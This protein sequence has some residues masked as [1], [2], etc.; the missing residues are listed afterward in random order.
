MEEGWTHHI[1]RL[2]VLSNI[3][4][5]LD[6]NPR[7]LTDWFHVAFI[8]AYDWVVEPNVL[9]M[10]TFATGS[11][12]MTKPYVAGS[13]YINRMSDHCS[14]CDFHPKKTCPISRMYWAYLARHAPAFSGNHRLSMAMRNVEKRSEE[15][16]QL[17]HATFLHVQQTLAK[18]GKLTPEN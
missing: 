9:G 12:M 4:H 11:A 16:R 6:V 17:D 2:M 10:G 8:D 13:A 3:A 1:P 18:G 15:Q 7:E 14:T 5:L